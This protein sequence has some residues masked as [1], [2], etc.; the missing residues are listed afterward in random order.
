MR[1]N[2]LVHI[3]QLCGTL[4]PFVAREM[5]RQ[6][7]ATWNKTNDV[8]HHVLRKFAELGVMCFTVPEGYGGTGRDV[9]AT[10]VVIEDA[11]EVQPGG[12]RTLSYSRLIRRHELG[13]TYQR[14]TE[15]DA[16]AR[17]PR[18]R[19]AVCLRLER[20][21]WRRRPRQRAHQ[22]GASRKHANHQI[23][24]NAFVPAPPSAAFDATPELGP[25][26]FEGNKRCGRCP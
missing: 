25:R 2:E 6:Q 8:P 4:R 13:G 26:G 22:E 16:A 21:G 15:T 11:L 17:G 23:A 18:R 5:P 9:P 1:S 24:P 14:R 12:F 20:A 19:N 3:V 10:M 7:A